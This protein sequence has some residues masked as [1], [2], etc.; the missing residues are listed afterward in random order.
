VCPVNTKYVAEET[1]LSRCPNGKKHSK[2]SITT[3]QTCGKF[4]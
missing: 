1:V 3:K 2:I 4:C